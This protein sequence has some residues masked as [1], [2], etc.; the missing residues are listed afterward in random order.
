MLPNH[1]R[2]AGAA[3]AL[4]A[5]LAAAPVS[6]ARRTSSTTGSVL[7]GPVTVHVGE[8]YTVYGSGFAPGA[9]VP[10]EIAEADGCCIALNMFADSD[11]RFAYTGEVWAPGSYS[12]RAFVE[13]NGRW[14]A[15]GSW[16]FEAYP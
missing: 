16:S 5:L 8:L 10:L 11:G 3:L 15:A 6:A 14:R 9:M 2:S 7:T 1:V 4:A 12:V 13:R